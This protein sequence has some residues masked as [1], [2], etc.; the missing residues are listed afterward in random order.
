MVA[1]SNY[2]SPPDW[3]WAVRIYYLPKVNGTGRLRIQQRRD[4]RLHWAAPMVS[5]LQRRATSP[6]GYLRSAACSR[7]LP[8]TSA[9]RRRLPTAA[10]PPP[11][12]PRRPRLGQS[13]LIPT[14]HC[15]R[16]SS[17]HPIP[18][19]APQL[20]SSS[21]RVR[22]GWGSLSV[23]VDQ[24]IRRQRFRLTRHSLGFRRPCCLHR[25]FQTPA[26]RGNGVFLLYMIL[27]V[28]WSLKQGVRQL[29]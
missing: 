8:F 16:F 14:L 3:A 7:R 10:A 4:E 6:I 28:E 17:S 21:R 18:A 12:P 27:F 19:R 13:R 23:D 22:W 25:L 2:F 11:T 1:W 26:V 15:T 29:V 20:V 9:A 5:P 24:T